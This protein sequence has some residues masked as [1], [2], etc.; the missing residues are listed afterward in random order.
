MSLNFAA[1]S[2]LKETVGSYQRPIYC[3]NLWLL[4]NLFKEFSPILDPFIVAF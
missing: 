3:D 2:L 4:V 1:L